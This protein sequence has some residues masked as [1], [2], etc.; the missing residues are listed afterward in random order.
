MNQ[1]KRVW[2]GIVRW[3]RLALLPLLLVVLLP[4]CISIRMSDRKIHAYFADK[5]RRPAFRTI[6]VQGRPVHYAVQGPDSLPT[7]LFI[8]GS[9]GSWDAFIGFFSDS[10]LYTRARL[11]SVDRPGFG[12][13]GLGEPEVSLKMQAA[14]LAPLLRLSHTERKPI[15][16][17]HSL[18]GPV[19][20]RLAMDYPGEV[21][22]LILVAPSIDPDLEK[23]EW[24]RP[25]GAMFPFREL[26]PTE[27]DVSNR[28]I[29]PLKGELTRLLPHW[30]TVRVPVTVIQGEEDPLVPP[31]N[32]DFARKM[33]VHAPLTIQMIPGMNHFIPWSRPDLISNAILN[34]LTSK[35]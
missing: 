24:Y 26:I 7:V 28:E 16:V 33:L 22:G 21:G 30:R 18:G 17:G 29:L 12:K 14:C 35:R 23:K 8:H 20:A 2:S 32:A 10:A 27:L 15:L 4:R 9:P 34:Q 13:S 31:G 19:A 3:R 6:E 11:V 5:P 25:I 1:K